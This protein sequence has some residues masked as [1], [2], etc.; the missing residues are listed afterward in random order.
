VPQPVGEPVQPAAAVRLQYVSL[1]VEVGDVGDLVRLQAVFDVVMACPLGR[2]LDRP[3]VA[4]EFDLLVVTERLAAEDH[5][6]VA[7]DRIL[8]GVAVVGLQR[9]RK[10]DA[11]NLGHEVRTHGLDGDAHNRFLRL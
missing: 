9:L 4:R 3:E 8:D 5:D 7:V 2:G 1:A 11:G 10:V 6:S